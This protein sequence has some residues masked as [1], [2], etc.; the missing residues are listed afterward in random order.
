MLKTFIK[1]QNRCHGCFF[2][3][4]KAICVEKMH[5]SLTEIDKNTKKNQILEF[6]GVFV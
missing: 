4:L 1:E 2:E 5:Q 6:Y 3:E